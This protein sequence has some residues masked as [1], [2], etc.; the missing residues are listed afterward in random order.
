[1]TGVENIKHLRATHIKPWSAADN[2]EKLDGA[3]GLLL[4]PRYD[5]YVL[6]TTKR[7]IMR[8]I[9]NSQTWRERLKN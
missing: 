8:I 7:P 4:S 9:W 6:A 5:R 1:M 3:K 2:H